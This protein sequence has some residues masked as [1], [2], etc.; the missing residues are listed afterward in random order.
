MLHDEQ[1]NQPL[2]RLVTPMLPLRFS[3]FRSPSTR[4]YAH[5]LS[6]YDQARV[7]RYRTPFSFRL[8]LRAFS[9]SLDLSVHPSI[10]WSIAPCITQ[11]LAG[12]RDSVTS[13]PACFL[14]IFTV[15]LLRGGKA[16][17]KSP[18]GQK[19]IGRLLVRIKLSIR[20]STNIP[21]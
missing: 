3:T 8:R 9:F 18:R 19:T 4:K 10:S 13:F 12:K 2:Q 15:C 7:A 6:G 5:G 14:G 11:T 20:R 16:E 1:G 17:T 21:A